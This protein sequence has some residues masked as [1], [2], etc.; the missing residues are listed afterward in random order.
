MCFNA[1]I[2]DSVIGFL[3]CLFFFLIQES[4][5]SFVVAFKFTPV[6]GKLEIGSVVGYGV[7]LTYFIGSIFWFRIEFFYN[8]LD[9]YYCLV[10]K[11]VFPLFV[12]LP[13]GAHFFLIIIMESACLF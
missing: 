2:I 11:I 4:I 12:I 3:N 7:A 8:A 10:K 5:L 9:Q 6:I 13:F 1:W